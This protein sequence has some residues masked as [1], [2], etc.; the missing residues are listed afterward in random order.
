MTWFTVVKIKEMKI[1]FKE[2][3]SDVVCFACKLNTTGNGYCWM[4]STSGIT[5]KI[6]PIYEDTPLKS[7]NKERK[8]K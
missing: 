3:E 8:K 4:H 1:V 5:Y 2:N 7:P 6:V